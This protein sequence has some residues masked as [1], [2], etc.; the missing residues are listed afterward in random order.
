LRGNID[1]EKLLRNGTKWQYRPR[2]TSTKLGK[3]ADQYLNNNRLRFERNAQIIYELEGLLPDRLLMHCKIFDI[4]GKTLRMQVDPGPYMFELRTESPELIEGLRRKYPR[5]GI[6]RISLIVRTCFREISEVMEAWGRLLPDKLLDV[7]RIDEIVG[8]QMTVVFRSRK[9][10]A[11]FNID[12][13]R[14]VKHLGFEC[15]ECGI[16]KIKEQTR[17]SAF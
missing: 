6:N 17:S 15:P 3:K 12:K 8:D 1:E 11:Q 13:E 4:V 2:Q 16:R 14:L 9:K 7:C 5:C 10:L